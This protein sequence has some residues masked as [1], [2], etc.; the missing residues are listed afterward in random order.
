MAFLQ[1]HW[2]KLAAAALV[3]AALWVVG[4]KYL[5]GDQIEWLP[6]PRPAADYTLTDANGRTVK[7]ADGQGKV[8]LYYFF[9]SHCPDVCPQTTFTLS[10]LQTA[11]QKE[12]LLG[13]QVVINSISFDPARDTPERLKEFSAPFNPV[14]G[15]WNFLTGTD[16]K[17]MAELAKKY[18]VSVIKDEKGNFGHY[19]MYVLVDKK[20]M[21]RK[22]F[23][24]DDEFEMQDAVKALKAL[25]E[26]KV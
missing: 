5:K 13:G 22:Y 8:R 2:F 20:D 12:G 15:A 25:A 4:G 24:V 21:I 18:M 19:N 10:K 23:V 7:F 14:P 9:F 3:L 11:L 17:E 26:E 6:N 16:E 1:K